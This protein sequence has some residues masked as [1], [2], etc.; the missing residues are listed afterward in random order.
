MGQKRFRIE[1]EELDHEPD[2]PEDEDEAVDPASQFS[3]CRQSLSMNESD[4][5]EAD[6]DQDD[7]PAIDPEHLA[8]H[9]RQRCECIFPIERPGDIGAGNE[10]PEVCDPGEIESNQQIVHGLFKWSSVRS[11]SVMGTKTSRINGG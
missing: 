11:A 3:A 6:N 10:N 2:K 1:N 7:E 9:L 4:R 5:S 8:Q